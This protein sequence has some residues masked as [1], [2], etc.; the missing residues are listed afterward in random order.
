MKT[1]SAKAKGRILQQY[2]AKTII[3]FFEELE[4][5]DV[6]SRPMG[7]GGVD[8]MLSPLAQKLF[9]VSVEAKNTKSKP[10]PGEL[11]QSRANAY[12]GTVPVVA[13]KP[14][15]KGMQMTMVMMTLDDLCA[16]INQIREEGDD[17]ENLT[18]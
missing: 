2:I 18:S 1:A 4:E 11:A 14:P 6:V 7:S 3:A 9:P 16:L 13:W 8:I 10:G 17:V 12:D 5:D 15:G